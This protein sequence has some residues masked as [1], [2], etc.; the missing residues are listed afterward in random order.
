MVGIGGALLAVI[1]IRPNLD[2]YD[3]LVS[4]VALQLVLP[5]ECLLSVA[6]LRAGIG[7]AALRRTGAALLCVV[8]EGKARLRLTVCARL[9]VLHM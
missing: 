7:L 8:R 2:R 5:V 1:V 9:S 3:C 6:S 4:G